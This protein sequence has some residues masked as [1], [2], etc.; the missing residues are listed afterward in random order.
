MDSDEEDTQDKDGVKPER[1]MPDSDVLEECYE[2]CK[3]HNFLKGLVP[4]MYPKEKKDDDDD[5]SDE[6]DFDFETN[7]FFSNLSA[8]DCQ[9]ILDYDFEHGYNT[10]DT[11][12]KMDFLNH[13][14]SYV[15]AELTSKALES[16]QDATAKELI[17]KW[18][19]TEEGKSSLISLANLMA[20]IAV[21][22]I[23]M[24]QL[25][26]FVAIN[27]FKQPNQ[28]WRPIITFCC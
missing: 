2:K 28:I 12:D 24:C 13:L 1:V 22:I 3:R 18:A 15:K 7:G 25:A 11:K 21:R 16:V 17:E 23:E 10:K 6:E 9:K 14:P 4:E 5:D 19:Y 20:H 27:Q 26:I 8:E